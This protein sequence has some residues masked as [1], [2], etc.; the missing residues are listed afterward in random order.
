MRTRRGS[1]LALAALL[2]AWLAG[3]AETRTVMR[4]DPQPQLVANRIFPAAPEIP[5]F[6]Y[7]GQLLG[8][9][10][11]VP[12][13]A[14][15]RGS[16]ARLL[17][18]LVGLGDDD[19]PKLTLKRPQA[20]AVDAQGRVFVSDIANHAV[21]V[22]NP[23]TGKLQVWA[24]AEP[25]LRFVTPVGV[26]L[27]ANGELLVADAELGKVIRL[28]ADGKPAGSFGTG[29]LQRPTGL[30]RDA[31]HGRIYVAD[32]HGHDIKVFSDAG[33]LLQ[34]I[35]R[36]GEEPGEFNFPT[37]LALGPDLLLVADT[38]N[39]R[40]QMLGLDGTPRGSIGRRGL[41]IGNLTLPKGVTIDAAGHIYIIESLYDTLLVFDCEGNFLMPIGGSGKETGQFYL[42]SGLWH[43][44]HGRI[45]VAD[46]FNGRIVMFEAL[47]ESP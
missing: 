16:G 42:P 8:E 14:D 35:G 25:K 3:C 27:G 39:A 7:V 12:E 36:R 28:G 47:G 20:G 21:M 44:A 6:R 5:R 41:K 46:M 2:L 10:N 4:L 37:H 9:E 1:V 45:Y 19:E 13:G 23:V 17:Q 32:S 34:T 40:V 38:M 26:A 24:Q 22:F 11:F 31:E 30:A 33:Q 43:D 18:W 29:L 15:A